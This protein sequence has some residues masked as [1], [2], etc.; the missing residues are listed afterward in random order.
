MKKS[1]LTVACASL[2]LATACKNNKQMDNPFLG[3][4]NTPYNIPDFEKIK[5]EHY[6]PAFDEGMKQQKS[7]I[8]AIVNNTEAPSLPS[9]LTLK[10]WKL[11]QRR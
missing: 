5:P 6:L 1:L 9:A 8:D 11:S 2:L 7:E 3:E 4:W 10:R